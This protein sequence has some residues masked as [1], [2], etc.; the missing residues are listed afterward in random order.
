MLFPHCNVHLIVVSEAN[1]YF[2]D[3]ISKAYQALTDPVSRQ[4]YEKYGHPDGRQ[5]LH[6]P[7]LL[8]ACNK[9]FFCVFPPLKD[10]LTSWFALWYLCS[11]VPDRDC[12]ALLPNEQWWTLWWTY[13]T[14]NC[15]N[16]YSGSLDYSSGVSIMVIKIHRKLYHVWYL[17]HI[18]PHGETFS[19]S[20]VRRFFSPYASI[21]S[22]S[23][24]V[25]IF[26]SDF[27]CLMCPST[28][29]IFAF[30]LVWNF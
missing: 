15:R 26:M 22:R 20:K 11:G 12:F 30:I 7:N 13:F 17:N 24:K 29:K 3:F 1:N 16:C 8:R 14:W 18:L 28:T 19:R 4:N 25:S 23:L 27:F 6:I 5:V 9:E 2:V 21:F 10:S